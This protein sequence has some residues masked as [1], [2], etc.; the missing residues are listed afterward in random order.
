MAKLFENYCSHLAITIYFHKKSG[1][2]T[3]GFL[4]NF[5]ILCCFQCSFL[6][7]D[8]CTLTTT[9]ALIIQFSTA[10]TAR[11]IQ[12]YRVNIR[13]KERKYPFNANTV[14]DLTNSESSCR[15]LSLL[16]NNISSEG[17]DSFLV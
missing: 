16:L 10:N 17:L 11:F 14:R 2:L 1:R 8:P 4:K 3:S 6:F 9:L 15:T 12:Y 13:R 5:N 7:L